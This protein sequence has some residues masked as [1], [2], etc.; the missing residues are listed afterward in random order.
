MFTPPARL[1]QEEL[2]DDV[3]HDPETLRASMEQVAAVD[4]W[5]GGRRGV[6]RVLK[7][8]LRDASGREDDRSRRGHRHDP[9]PPHGH[10]IADRRH[11]PD[12]QREFA[13]L[14]VGTGNG[15]V[16]SETADWVRGRGR[17]VTAIGIDMHPEIVPLARG[18]PRAHAVRGDGL[19]LPFA[20]DA[21]DVAITTLTLHH[22]DA[23]AAV[24]LLREMARVARSRVIVSDL[25]RSRLH[26]LGARLLAETVWRGNALTRNDGPISVL[27]SFTSPELAD[28]AREAGLADVRVRRVH[29]FRL[30]M[31]GRP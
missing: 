11:Q 1:D 16:L 21:F 10:A 25:E 7:D 28:L 14:D 2:L 15:R 26:Y 29:P 12:R 9:G 13:I 20:D 3:G 19:R 17:S 4:R 27:R 22:F 31:E 30:V 8:V 6:R 5:L 18:H 23:Q 24:A